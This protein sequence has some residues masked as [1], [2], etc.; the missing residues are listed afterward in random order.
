LAK[1]AIS[2]HAVFTGAPL[3]TDLASL[4][5]AVAARGRD[6]VRV[7]PKV[8]TLESAGVLQEDVQ[9]NVI[10]STVIDGD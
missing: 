1:N 7:N 8:P 3:M 6:P 9:G 4:R 5:D 10:A 2:L